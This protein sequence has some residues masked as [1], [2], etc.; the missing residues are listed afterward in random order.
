MKDEMNTRFRPVGVTLI[1][2]FFIFGAAMSGLTAV[3]LESFGIDFHVVWRLNPR[4]HQGFVAMGGWAIVL[5]CVVCAACCVAAIGLWRCARWG[6]W[7]ALVILGVNL[8]GDTTNA[9]VLRDWRTLIGL[10]VGGLMIAY[11]IVR[12]SVFTSGAK[13][14]FFSR[15]FR[16]G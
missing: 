7:T 8:V 13:A 9:F 10:P 11:L 1:A 5:M 6:Y 2:L 15:H 16:H 14:P 12:R 4:A 3:M